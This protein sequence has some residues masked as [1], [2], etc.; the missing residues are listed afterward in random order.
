MREPHRCR[1]LVPRSRGGWNSASYLGFYGFV[2]FAGYEMIGRKLVHF[3]FGGSASPGSFPP[4]NR[5][6]M[7]LVGVLLTLPHEVERVSQHVAAC[8]SR[9]AK[10]CSIHQAMLMPSWWPWCLRRQGQLTWLGVSI[11]SEPQQRQGYSPVGPCTQPWSLPLQTRGCKILF[12]FLCFIVFLTCWNGVPLFS[13]C[14]PMFLLLMVLVVLL[15]VL[16]V[17][18]CWC[19]CCWWWWC[20]GMYSTCVWLFFDVLHVLTVLCSKPSRHTVLPRASWSLAVSPI[21]LKLFVMVFEHLAYLASAS[22]VRHHHLSRGEPRS[23]CCGA[24]A[25]TL[26][27]PA[28]AWRVRGGNECSPAS[29]RA[30]RRFGDGREVGWDSVGGWASWQGFDL[31]IFRDLLQDSKGFTEDANPCPHGEVL[32]SVDFEG[33]VKD[34]WGGC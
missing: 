25:H 8:R 13:N 2:F 19:C 5:C 34:W 24:L 26:Q 12:L 9:A 10:S 30:P 4:S 6:V 29:S 7:G 14:W 33:G 23:S 15:L 27:G 31:R 21:R 11:G 16:L 20:K 17:L 18:G 1:V 3:W 22:G 28:G 32:E